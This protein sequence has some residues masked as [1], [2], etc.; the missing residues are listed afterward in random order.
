MFLLLS[1]TDWGDHPVGPRRV[2][3]SSDTA[4]TSKA[5]T[6]YDFAHTLARARQ[7]YKSGRYLRATALLASLRPANFEKPE[8]QSLWSQ[9]IRL[10]SK[11]F[12]AAAREGR[13]SLSHSYQYSLLAAGFDAAVTTQ[14]HDSRTLYIEMPDMS[15]T[16]VHQ[17]IHPRATTHA[18]RAEEHIWR[19]LTNGDTAP[20]SC[21][22]SMGFTRVILTNGRN[23]RWEYELN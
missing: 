3:F 13:D 23:Q 16:L 18:H 1:R 14:G 6:E 12:E 5:S 10:E 19:F 7:A 8:V 20:F 4:G 21:W 9:A 22:R 17:L 2:S 15:E 11:Q